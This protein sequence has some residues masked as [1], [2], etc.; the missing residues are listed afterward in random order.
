MTSRK[1]EAV[2][3]RPE[4]T[5]T[6]TYL[7]VP[8]DTVKEFGTTSQVRVKGTVDGDPYRSTLLPTGEG[9]H[10]LVVKSDIRRAI[11][12]EAGEVVR[13]AMGPDSNPRS[14]SVPRD[15]LRAIEGDA[16]AKEAFGRMA[17]SHRKAY[18]DWVEQ[19]KKQETRDNRIRRPST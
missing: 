4:G 8:F 3:V 12:K 14:V 10:L 11:G 18:V 17:Y 9:G 2:L 6:W 5:G 19:G 7:V 1:F 13:V 16:R 15:L